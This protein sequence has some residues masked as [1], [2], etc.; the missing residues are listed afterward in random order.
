MQKSIREEQ[1]LT[2]EIFP[3]SEA[4]VVERSPVPTVRKS[5]PLPQRRS[6]ND[7]ELERPIFGSKFWE[8]LIEQA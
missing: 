4:I 1:R 8:K 2:F 7:I 5:L 3:R 6:V